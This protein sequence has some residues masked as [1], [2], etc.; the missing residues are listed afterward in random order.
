MSSSNAWVNE[1]ELGDEP[2]DFVDADD[3]PLPGEQPAAP[4]CGRR[5]SRT[6]APL[7]GVLLCAP[8]RVMDNVLVL[9]TPVPKTKAPRAELFP[10]K[11]FVLMPDGT[12]EKP[13][14]DKG[15]WYTAFDY[16]VGDIASLHEAFERLRTCADGGVGFVVAGAVA[17]GADPRG[18][19]RTKSAKA[20]VRKGDVLLERPKPKGLLDAAR[21]WLIQDI[22][23]IPARGHDPRR[24][25]DAARAYL[26][27]LLPP[28]IRG[29]RLSWQWSSSCCV[30]GA[31][32]RPLAANTPPATLGVH[33]RV[34]LDEALNERGR[35]NLLTRLRA[36]ATARLLE[37]GADPGK[38]QV[39]DPATAT[40]NQP[41]YSCVAF[42]GGVQD[43]FPGSLRSGL[44]VE[45]RD[46][47]RVAVILEQAPAPASAPPRELTEAEKAER[48]EARK[49]A[50][51]AAKDRKEHDRLLVAASQMRGR[52]RKPGAATLP[53]VAPRLLPFVRKRRLEDRKLAG[54]E[55]GVADRKHKFRVRAMA[56]IVALVEDRRERDTAWKDGVPEGMRRRVLFNVSALLSWLVPVAELPAAIEHFGERLTSRRWLEDEWLAEDKGRSVIARAN[57]AASV[58]AV[59]GNGDSYRYDPWHARIMDLLQP[60][61]EEQLRLGLRTLRSEAVRSEVRRRTAGARTAEEYQEGRRAQAVKPWTVAG[62]TRSTWYRQQAAA[63]AAL[64]RVPVG[65]E[66][67]GLHVMVAVPRGGA[68][69][70]YAGEALGRSRDLASDMVPAAGGGARGAAGPGRGGGGPHGRARHPVDPGG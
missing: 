64:V 9:R 56:D 55:R 24:D 2:Y 59:G 36:Y 41:V 38:A 21:H 3:L 6:L 30:I 32:G 49:R 20:S 34:W 19:P 1:I 57:D 23:K 61:E 53:V 8:D 27:S 68:R 12:V 15:A 45:G 62:M 60:T 44:T 28:E 11:R 26:L 69:G 10:G 39:V 31:D 46:E 14:Y 35:R 22:D 29:A 54:K 4:A 48:A 16:A 66:A 5:R 52:G 17:P 18:M 70:A 7:Q 58:N 63:A 51:Q 40:Y 47:V 67:T 50:R 65:S 25:P 37:L 33:L 42:E 13:P 43:P